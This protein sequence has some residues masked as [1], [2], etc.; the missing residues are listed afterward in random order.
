M[1][2]SAASS[3]QRAEK[4]LYLTLFSGFLLFG[5]GV[6]IIGSVLPKLIREFSWSYTATGSVLAAG[7]I[8]YFAASFAVGLIIHRINARRL[9]VMSLILR[10]HVFSYLQV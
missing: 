9:I 1:E 6:T 10:Q 7:S 3:Q 2:K 8:G 4:L 5:L